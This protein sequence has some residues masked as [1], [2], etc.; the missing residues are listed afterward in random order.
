MYRKL[1]IGV[2]A[3]SLLVLGFVPMIN[4]NAAT[5]ASPRAVTAG[6]PSS[7]TDE[8]K[9][10]HYFGPYPNWAYSPQTLANAVVDLTNGG[11]TGAAATANV[12]PKTGGISSFTITSAGSG[13]TAPPDV[14]ITSP[15][16]T[17][18]AVASGTAIISPGVISS[19]AVNENGFGFTQPVV[20]FSGGGVV[21]TPAAA[22]AYGG[23]DDV[24]LVD[25]G[26][27]Y[28][29]APIVEFGLPT[30]PGGT[31]AQGSATMSAGSVT[32]VEIT[33]PGSGYA[34]A[35]TVTVYDAGHV[36]PT[37]AATVTS[38]INV[39]SIAVTTAGA[40]YD[41]APT[42]DISDTAPGTG[43]DATATATVSVLGGVTGITVVA[44]GSGYLTPGLKKFVDTLPGLGPTAANNLG[45][46]IPVAV[47]D[48][49]T[50][51]GTDYYE[52]GLVQYRQQL[53]SQL[54]ATLLRGYVQISTTTV[55][56]KQV[57]LTN[58]SVDPNG[59]ATPVAGGYL[60]VDNPMYLG[61][62]IV[63]QKDRP[64][65][66]LFRNLLPT[67]SDGDL[68]L[69]VDGTLM[70]S[71]P[72]PNAMTLDSN[73]VPMDMA[74][75]EG[76]VMDGVRN[77]PCGM[78]PKPSVCYSENRATLHLHGGLTPWIS[79][80]T[81]HQW[82]TPAG[83]ATDY[84]KGVSVYNV[85]DMP[86][87]GPGAETFFYTNQ[88]SA[89]LMFYHDHAW[90][91][92]R[93]NVMAGE[94]APY[95][96]TD[97]TEQKLFGTGGAFADLGVGTP[98]VVQDK[99]FVP[100]AATMANLDPTWDT[101]K[102]GGEGSIWA[103]HVYM[104]AQNPS[105][106][107]GM[108]SF[109]RW[110][111]G[112]W[113]WPPAT[114]TKYKS[115]ANP[116]FDS[117]CDPNVQPFCEPPTIPGTP[118][119]SVGM[120]Q[121]NDTPLVNGVVYPTT[122]VDPKAYRY[123]ILNAA[124][125][126]FWNLSWYVADPTTGTLSE[127][128]LKAD[129]VAKAQT[130]PVVQPT[131]DTAKSP[132]GPDW[133]QIGT[134]GGFLATPAVLPA[135]DITYIT[136]PTRFDVGNVD[137]GSLILAPAERADVI[138]DFSKYRGKTLILYNDAP[139]AYPARVP[140]YDFYTGGPDLTPDGAKGFAKPTL[141]GYG[142][143]TRTI[144]QV[145]VSTKAPATPFDRPNTTADRMGTLMGAFAHHTDGSGVF[146]S[147]SDP[148]IVGQ[149]A[150]NTAYGTSFVQSGYCNSPRSPSAKCDGFARIDEQGG[151]DPMTV[152][153][154]QTYA[155]ST[156]DTFKFDTL[157]GA[158]VGIPLKSKAIHDEMNSANFDEF[159]RMTA[160]L[161]V[162]APGATPL[163][164]NIT[165]YPYVNPTTENLDAT[166]LP[167]SLHVTPISVG[168]DGTQIWKITHNGVDTHPIHFHL[169][170]VQVINRVT[171]DN[172][173]IPPFPNEIGWKETVRISPLEDTIVA[174]RPIEPTLP[175]GVPNST[176]PLNPMMPIGA[177]GNPAGGATAT[178]AGFNNLFPDG[179]ATATPITNRVTNFGWEYVWHCHI[180]SHEEMDMMRPQDLTV[181]TTKP[182]APVL[183]FT[184]T[185]GASLTWTDGTPVNY[186]DPTTWGSPKG[187]VGFN[188]QRAPLSNSGVVGTWATINAALANK[189]TYLDATGAGTTGYAYRVVAWNAAGS[190]TSNQV[191]VAVLPGA[192]TG[193]AGTVGAG[194]VPLTW[195]APANT[196]GA[197]LT[198]NMVHYRAVGSPTWLQASNSIAG[199]AT[200][201]TVTGLTGGTAYEFRVATQNSVGWSAWS[202][203]SAP[204]TPT[205][206]ITVPAAPTSLAGT[207]GAGVANMT[208]T[209]ASNGG[210]ALTA[211]FIQYRAVGSGT[212]L[213]ASNTIAAGA[214]SYTVTGLTGGTAYEFRIAAQNSVGWSAWSATSASVTP[215]APITVPT[216]PRSFAGVVGTKLVNLSWL[217]P[218][219]NGGAALTAYFIQRR[220]TGSG[221]WT[222]VSN[223]IS[224][225]ATTY[226]VTGLTTGTSY[227]F[228][229]AVSNS[230]GWS[231]WSTTVTRT[232]L[233]VVR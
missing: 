167:S 92:T 81:P 163:L 21:T 83:E 100:K 46:Y 32:G 13:Y 9:V 30:G 11:G 121:F 34:S 160:N 117:T 84:P 189:V 25:G 150:Y 49:T 63:A 107:S 140:Q 1:T 33:D 73:G 90:G 154:N 79:D 96:V 77:P 181:P 205:V 203:T 51:P 141:P 56:G 113:F 24:T 76:T 130:D 151:L 116:Y 135:H 211:N 201:Y 182:D 153:G 115:I 82:V 212:W 220:V 28:T 45:N 209:A 176:R 208:W 65:R 194:K 29:S 128:A 137:Y 4:A 18:T 206:P 132:A 64:T 14:A 174:L 66:I 152:N 75:D 143:N 161:G 67:G 179:N 78:T 87:P 5:N 111:Y 177:R 198:A 112:P 89:R 17:P 162:E 131:V 204:V 157:N 102:W 53:S 74:P 12:D 94:A 44:A 148:I 210:A 191:T 97:A 129:E 193:L 158:Q 139:A 118:N 225:A 50:Y 98:L 40:G 226:Q 123:R 171:W 180:L 197:A 47:P 127:V 3:G 200:S 144:M 80:G 172:I 214:T 114:D 229:I 101:A 230:V 61:P 222:T 217:A 104:P 35:P 62:T 199:N 168:T 95:L 146:E 178:E 36:L 175:F 192:P 233:R 85:P 183:T 39:A 20:T 227:D 42:V 185:G 165:L 57:P 147:G 99:T 15:G 41:S 119:I 187:E 202:A 124:N 48:T 166:N 106:P 38:T 54:P 19:V 105:D 232:P 58:A 68:F 22:Q 16:V 228:R 31:Q 103:A 110:F 138:V 23:V 207:P 120:E 224:P 108:S 223:T 71:G 213:T 72:G 6:L 133:I 188:V 136:D 55:P 164:Q 196:G 184:R 134:E 126:R 91:V 219:S 7:P 27:G 231:A 169:Y 149:A 26:S 10:P 52:I 125:D 145:K 155:G 60:G 86:D 93:L 218:S 88:Q 59:A 142:P 2:A 122:T 69:P 195:T 8:T 37:T 221:T 186:A 43:R 109:G 156:G 70:G 190:S 216:A 173:V 159:G 215:T 170:N